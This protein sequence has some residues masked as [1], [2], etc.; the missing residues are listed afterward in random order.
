MNRKIL[1]CLIAIITNVGM[2]LGNNGLSF[3][4]EGDAFKLRSLGEDDT[5]GI[6]IRCF[7]MDL[8]SFRVYDLRNLKRKFDEKTY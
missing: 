3:L 2:V 8:E 7:W 6:A 5:K 1:L 4:S